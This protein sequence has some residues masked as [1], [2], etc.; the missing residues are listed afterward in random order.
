[1]RQEIDDPRKYRISMS[2]YSI[3]TGWGD[4]KRIVAKYPGKS[5]PLDE[6]AFQQWLN[7]A[8]RICELYNASLTP[9]AELRCASDSGGIVD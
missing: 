7:D 8:E 4:E 6:K 3:K 2:G 1:M 5:N 9:N